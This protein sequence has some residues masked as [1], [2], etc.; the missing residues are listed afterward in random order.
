MK[1]MY[2]LYINF[3]IIN[4][5]FQIHKTFHLNQQQFAFV[6]LFLILC[7]TTI[8]HTPEYINFIQSAQKI[9]DAKFGINTI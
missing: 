7:Q 1:K 2:I 8:N 3:K 4:S 6:S 5:T 9:S